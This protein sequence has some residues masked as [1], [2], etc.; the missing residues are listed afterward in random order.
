M[1]RYIFRQINYWECADY[2]HLWKSLLSGIH[3]IALQ[4]MV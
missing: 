2:V 3:V 4:S 1:T